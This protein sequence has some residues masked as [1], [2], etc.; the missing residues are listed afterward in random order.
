MLYFITVT[1]QKYKRRKGKENNAR[2]PSYHI[3]PVACA[4]HPRGRT[5]IKDFFTVNI[6]R[7]LHHSHYSVRKKKKEK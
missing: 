3:F 7:N 1:Q 6:F 2:V 5:E 4:W